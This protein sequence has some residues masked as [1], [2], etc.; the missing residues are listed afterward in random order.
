M[1]GVDFY[2]RYPVQPHH[3][4]RLH[5]EQRVRRPDPWKAKV[6]GMAHP[7]AESHYRLVLI[8]AD[9][10]MELVREHR[11]PGRTRERGAKRVLVD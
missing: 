11:T 7:V 10:T 6:A 3:G 8:Q 5:V 2:L 9:L 1:Y 4:A